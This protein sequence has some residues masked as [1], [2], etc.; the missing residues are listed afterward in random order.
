MAVEVKGNG[1]TFEVGVPKALFELRVPGLPGPRNYYVVAA[2]GRRFLVIS[3]LEEATST[4]TTVV[5][6]WTAD[7]R[8]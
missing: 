8:R 6:N 7:L 2:D 4:P 3:L 1:S 5:L